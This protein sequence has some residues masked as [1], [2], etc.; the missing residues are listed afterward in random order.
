VE[1]RGSRPAAPPRRGEGVPREGLPEIAATLVVLARRILTPDRARANATALAVENGRITAVGSRADAKRWRDR[2][3]EVIDAPD[4]TVIPGLVDAHA[5]LD[6]EGL[7]LV[8]PSLARCRS[9]ADIQRVIRGLAAERKPGEWIVTMPVGAPPFYLDPPSTLAERRWPTRADLDA[10]APDHPVYVRGIWGYWNKPPVYSIANSAALRRA[11]ITRDTVPPKGVEILKDA[12]GE[13][14][15]VFVES[16]LV[17][18]L[19]FSLMKDAPRFTPADRLKALAASQ[20]VYAAR[21]VT[22]I[23]EGH[24]IAPE[25]LAA[26]RRAH[27]AGTLRVRA[28]LAV[29]P[30]WSGAAEAAEAIPDLAAWAGGRGLGDDLLRVGGICLHAGGDA[31]V[32]RILHAAQPYTGWAGFVESTNDRD[33]YLAQARLCARHG[34]RVHTLVTRFLPETLAAWEAVAAETPIAPLRWVAV[35]LNVAID[36]DL[37]RLRRLGAVATTNPISY[38]WRSAAAEAARNG[39]DGET[40]IPHKA[41]LRHRIPFGIATDNKPANPWVAFRAVVERRD[42][43]SGAIVGPGQRLTRAQAL[44]ALTVGGAEVMFAERDRGVLA[45]GRAADFAVMDRDPLTVPAGEIDALRA[46]ATVV[47]GRVIH[48]SR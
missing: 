36:A 32:S 38:L 14:T 21:G 19:E 33:A 48:R 1:A 43:A 2:R 23:Y 47:G 7:K 27:E 42:L 26:Y 44:R 11:G 34:V 40:L 24:G 3:T 17:Q 12:T 30:T 6:R 41:L 22:A 31:E 20:A 39:G 5:H 25:V 4:A 45:A 15:G 8:Y 35:H 16:N 9:I 28:T 18:V 29:S 46:L 37:A 13:P 10:A